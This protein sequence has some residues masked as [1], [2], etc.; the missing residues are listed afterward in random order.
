MPTITL[1]KRRSHD[2]PGGLRRR[3]EDLSSAVMVT[4]SND[5]HDLISQLIETLHLE[6]TQHQRLLRIL[7]EKKVR[8]LEGEMED[9]ETLLRVEKEVLAD[10]VTMQRDRVSLITELGE[11]LGREHPSSLR[12]AE[13]VLYSSPEGRDELLDLRDEFRDVADE[14][15]ALSSVEPTFSQHRSGQIRLY[16]DAG[17]VDLADRAAAESHYNVSAVD[18]DL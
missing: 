13:L 3:L 1:H 17:H 14:F 16:L 15:E 5:L 12:L 2:E 8:C 11:I 6:L 10:L 7:R 9:M 18:G 4:C